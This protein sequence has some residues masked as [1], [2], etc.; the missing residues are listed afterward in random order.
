[1][2]AEMTGPLARLAVIDRLDVGPV[3]VEPDR[4]SAPSSDRESLRQVFREVALKLD[5]GFEPITDH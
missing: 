4:I 3:K 1:M 5:Y 2:N